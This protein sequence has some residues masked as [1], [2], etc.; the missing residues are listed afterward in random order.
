MLKWQFKIAL[1]LLAKKNQNSAIKN[2]FFNFEA[3]LR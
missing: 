2:A 1:I 3:I